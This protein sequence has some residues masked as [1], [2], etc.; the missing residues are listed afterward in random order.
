MPAWSQ[1]LKSYLAKNRVLLLW[2]GGVLFIAL[3]ERILLSAFYPPVAYNDSSSYRSLANAIRAGWVGY[4][5]TRTPGYPMFLA[6]VGPDQV[7]YRVQQILGLLVTAIFFYL[8]WKSTNRPAIGALVAL[9]HTLNMGQLF[10]E[11]NL[12][13]ETL[14]TSAASL[15]SR[16]LR[17]LW[18]LTPFLY[19]VA[20]TVWIT[21]VVQTLLDHG[22]NPRFLVPMQSWVVFWV[23]WICFFSIQAWLKRRAAPGR[24]PAEREFPAGQDPLRVRREQALQPGAES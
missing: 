5:G 16:R 17:R 20:T 4:D 23:A 1:S 2:L 12:L 22:D 14:A 3:I 19:L 15:L 9:L 6:I 11:A 7:V 24:V 10:F 8:G 13:T 18:G 21:S